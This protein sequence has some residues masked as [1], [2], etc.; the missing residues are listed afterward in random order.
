DHPLKF[1]F[2]FSLV[3]FMTVALVSGIASGCTFLRLARSEKLKA[4]VV[5]YLRTEV[6][7]VSAREAEVDFVLN[8]RNPNKIGLRNVSVDYELFHEG[9]PFLK[10]AGIDAALAPAGDTELRIP[11]VIAYGSVFT[12]SYALTQRII[13]GDST[14]P[15]RIDA[16]V[17]GKP[18]LY[19]ETESGSLFSFSK[20]VSRVVDVPIP[21]KQRDDATD[22]GKKRAL[23]ELKKRF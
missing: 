5:T 7:S 22:A 12:T 4:P 8:A 9:R 15:V 3:L 14:V 17:S 20:A 18:T 16:V 2:L 10:G 13:A 19:N 21:R 23:D 11:A 6:R 1:R